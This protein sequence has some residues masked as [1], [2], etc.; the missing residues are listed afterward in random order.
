MRKKSFHLL[1]IMM[2]IPFLIR[3]EWISLN[4][5]KSTLTPPHVTL[6][7]DDN[8]STVLKIEIS[9]FDLKEIV[10]D[11]KTYQ[12]ADLLSESF[13]INPGF[14]E[15]P[16]ISRVLAIPDHAGVSVEVLETGE[17]QSFTN[18]TL[19][20]ARESWMEG[21]PE[22][23][24]T[25]NTKVYNSPKSYP[26][27]FVRFDQPSVF[28]DFRITRV[29]VFPIQYLPAKKELQVVNSITIRITYDG[30]GEIVNPKNTLRKPIAPSFGKLYRSFIFNYQSVLDNLYGGKETGHEL[31]LCIMPDD[32]AASFQAYADWKRK[33]GIDIEITKFS[34]I[35][36]NSTNPDIIK[37]HIADAYLNWEVPPT[38]VLLVGDD[39][40]CPI[41]TSAYADENYFVEIEG[42]DYFPEM[43]I[44]RFTNQSDYGLQVMINKFM[45]YEQTP[46]TTSTGWFKKGICCSNDAFASQVET[47]RFAA[48]LMLIDGGFTS[49]DTMMS[50]PGCTYS[51]NDVVNA[52]NEGRSYLNYRGEGWSSG[53]WASCT[54]MHTADVSNLANGQK[55]TFVTSIGCGVAMFN[56]GGN[57]FGEE[58]VELGTI[59]NPRGASAFIG[60]TGN[61]HTTYNNKIDKGIYVGMFQEGMDTPGQA[62]LR[63]K[64]YMYNVFGNTGS[65]EY[66]YKIYCVL[67]DPSI[68][69]W[70]DVPQEVTVDYPPS[71]PFGNTTVEFTVTHTSTGLPVSNAV[72]CVTG[73]TLFS[74]GFTDESG[75]AYVDIEALKLETFNVTVRG[76][77]VIPYSG[78]MIVAPPVGPYVIYHSIE[79]NDE[80]GNN[81]G[82]METSE[83]ILATITVENIG[84]E[85]A[86]NVTVDIQ[87]TDPYVNITDDSE[88]YGDIG[89][90]TTAFVTDGF[91]WDVADNIP[92]LHNVIF[93]VSATDGSD[94]WLSY[95]EVVGHAPVLSIGNMTIDD[96][97]QGNGNGRLDAGETVDIYIK[98]FNNGSYDALNTTGEIYSGNPFITLNNVSHDF[99]T[100]ESGT[101][102]EAVF[103]VT[104][105]T[106]APVGESVEISFSVTSGGYFIEKLF[107]TKIGLILEDWEGGDMTQFDWQTGGNSEWFVTDNDPYEGVYCA[108]S[109]NI[110]DNQDSW[111]KL[112]YEVVN[113]DTISFYFKVS[114]ENS[115]D[116]LR[117]YINN[118]EMGE[119]SG[120]VGWQKASYAVMQGNYTFKWEYE[121]DFSIS[122][123]SDCAW[124]DYIVLPSSA[125]NAMFTAD[126]TE[127]CIDEEVQFTDFSSGS[128]TSWQWEFEGGDPATSNEQN[129]TVFYSAV[130]SYDVSLTISDGFGSNTLTLTDYINVSSTPGVPPTPGGPSVVCASEGISSYNTT[131]LT[132]ISVYD[133]MLE[134]SEAG[135]VTGTGLTAIVIW[136]DE[137][138]GEATLKVAGENNCGAGLYSDPITI[139]RYLPDVTLEPFDWVCVGWPS[140]ELSG[141]LP[142]GGEYSGPGVE[143]GWFNPALAGIGTHIIT[144]TYTDPEGCENLN[145]ETILVDPCTGVNKNNIDP[146]IL[147]YPNP[148]KGMFTLRLNRI[149]GKIDLELFN[150]MNELVL[151]ENNLNPAKD[152]NY[153]LDLNHLPAGIY[154]LHVSGNDIDH[155]R[156][157]VIQN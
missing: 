93:E 35:G 104:V 107:Y 22:S 20:P 62:M 111:L 19:P 90:D 121:K 112:D 117:F 14:P 66:H 26:G 87:T 61:T 48:D 100:I 36:A 64:F 47:K 149:T 28:R 145:S 50:D 40:V 120:Q 33:S 39:G 24:Y 103:N 5:N 89:A 140:F 37:N 135:N 67:G 85:I 30:T 70:K 131:G 157:I 129:P 29:S 153:N 13:T 31:M 126:N 144:Y 46:D 154:F 65:V 44:G 91:A 8:N 152:F 72:V 60:P 109:G 151:K 114:S 130:G 127:P 63:G 77:N 118:S 17:I 138:L 122:N 76:G 73:D 113:P 69:I 6:I 7:S 56:G 110:S 16:Y 125:L 78:T 96:S 49:V 106:S 52:I 53:W 147:I 133:W 75:N 38:Y 1:I 34:D 156:K 27:E 155:V 119:W 54:P 79:L 3:A 142:A 55:F 82:I 12:F 134:P 23:P 21:S 97:E 105:D 116:Y 42:N 95:V 80:A 4:K 141:G 2:F 58:W 32:F 94:T 15:V 139:T 98:T 9:G 99:G 41:H 10:S 123:G 136:E 81:N 84:V 59:S 71:V 150:T 83:S 92:D 25:E 137:F 102:E 86:A 124:L 148:G 143:N 128:P 101:M 108:Q 43:M 45:M 68:H 11:G 132:G 18:I 88:F 146:D 74:T 57:C 51:V 115:F